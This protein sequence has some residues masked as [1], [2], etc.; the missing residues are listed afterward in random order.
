MTRKARPVGINDVAIEVGD[1]RRALDFYQGFL[2]FD[3]SSQNDKA[4]FV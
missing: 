4:A 3:V 1:I 2:D